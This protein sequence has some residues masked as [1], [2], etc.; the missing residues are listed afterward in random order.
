LFRGNPAVDGLGFA[1]SYLG[2]SHHGIF[3]HVMERSTRD[4]QRATARTI[5]R[6]TPA[7]FLW[8][9]HIKLPN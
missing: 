2:H 5:D 9:H 8:Q 6:H 1:A 3:E 7:E 4:A